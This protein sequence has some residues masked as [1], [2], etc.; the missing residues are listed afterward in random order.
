MYS[1]LCNRIHY[2]TKNKIIILGN[3]N[4]YRIFFKYN[5]HTYIKCTKYNIRRTLYVCIDNT[6]MY[7][8]I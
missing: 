3:I 6:Y 1:I 4:I 5:I 2:T 7:M 8:S